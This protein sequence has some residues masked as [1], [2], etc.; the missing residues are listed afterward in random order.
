M[1]SKDAQHQSP[2]WPKGYWVKKY[3]QPTADEWQKSVETYKQERKAF[4]ELMEGSDDLLTP[5]DWGDGQSLL[6]EALTLA[7]HDA[8]HLGEILVLRRLL[9]NWN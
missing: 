4:I 1:F 2:E 7:D 8:Y 6:Q 3:H 5:L 9:G